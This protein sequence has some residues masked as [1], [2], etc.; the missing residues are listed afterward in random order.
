MKSHYSSLSFWILVKFFSF[1][2]ILNNRHF[3]IIFH[4]FQ[5]F[6]MSY[7]F[8]FSSAKGGPELFSAFL[9]IFPF[10]PSVCAVHGPASTSGCSSCIFVFSLFWT[11]YSQ[12]I[13]AVM[14]F[15][16]KN[17]QIFVVIV[18]KFKNHANFHCRPPLKGTLFI[19]ELDNNWF[20][21]LDVP[22]WLISQENLTP[23]HLDA[24]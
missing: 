17:R 23:R 21:S 19:W 8:F 18:N 2:K 4:L 6:V 5:L 7:K 12:D 1:W 20:I 14:C 16:V 11:W 15:L 10:L 13:R 9:T 22:P 3:E 24:Y